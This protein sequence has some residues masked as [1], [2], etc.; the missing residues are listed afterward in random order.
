MYLRASDSH[1]LVP[2]LLIALI[3]NFRTKVVTRRRRPRLLKASLW[4]ILHS[5]AGSMFT[6]RAVFTIL[7]S[8]TPIST[9]QASGAGSSAIYNSRQSIPLESKS[10]GLSA[11]GQ[12]FQHSSGTSFLISSTRC[13]T[14][15]FHSFWLWAIQ[16][17]ANLESV[18]HR[19]TAD[20]TSRRG[21]VCSGRGA[22]RV[23]EDTN[24][25]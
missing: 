17:Q 13:W 7:R 1:L 5:I 4:M 18:Q 2:V 24:L 14:N 20:N 11:P 19:T 10:A 3:I 9:R 25:T 21:M 22:T 8:F 23:L 12:W 15:G 6:A 16:Y